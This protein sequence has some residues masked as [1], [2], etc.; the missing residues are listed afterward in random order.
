LVPL[1]SGVSAGVADQSVPI[2]LA[3][4]FVV[5]IVVFLVAMT[6]MGAQA[7]RQARRERAR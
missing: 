3:V 6:V 5:N 1:A 7:V 4:A 2:G